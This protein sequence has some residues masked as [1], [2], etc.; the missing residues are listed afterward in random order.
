MSQPEKIVPA[1]SKSPTTASS[2]AAVV[3]GMPWSC[4]AGMKCGCTS[5]LVDIPQMK[6]PPASSQNGRV[7]APSTSPRTAARAAPVRTGSTSSAAVPPYGTTP[8]SR[9][10]S[11][12]SHATSGM[13]ASAAAVVPRDAARQPH[14]ESIQA[15]SGRKISCPAAPPAV[16]MPE[17]RPRRATNQRPVTVATSD[18]AIEPVPSPTSTPHSRISCQLVVMKTVS[19]LPSA[20]T[21][22]AHRT[23][24]RM[25]NRSISAAANGAVSP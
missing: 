21:S 23:T 18:S 22:R 24:R 7:F 3:T 20:T 15:T 1:M 25:P 19:P 6:N 13:T 12:S 2:P 4:A 9:G 14:T 17:T 11:R 5:P 16:R 8:R 10:R